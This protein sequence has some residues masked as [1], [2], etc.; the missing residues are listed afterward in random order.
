MWQYQPDNFTNPL[1]LAA[2]YLTFFMGFMS[3]NWFR[4]RFFGFFYILH[5][6][7]FVMLTTATFWHA[8]SS[9]YFLMPGLSL[10]MYDR[11]RRVGDMSVNVEISD[12][13]VFS[14][15]NSEKVTKVTIKLLS[16]APSPKSITCPVSSVSAFMSY[17]S[18]RPRHPFTFK[19]GQ[20][21]FLHIPR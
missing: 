21:A 8:A 17:F 7:T 1:V 11:C 12:I 2:T 4:R 18:P 19:A 20:Y 5:Q 10:W 6:A 16:A 14:V 13:Q 3:Q 9:W 15:G